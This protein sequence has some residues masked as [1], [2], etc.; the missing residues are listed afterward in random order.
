MTRIFSEEADQ[1]TPS[2]MSTSVKEDEDEMM[3]KAVAMS[4]QEQ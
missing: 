2:E 3:K 4:L 1:E